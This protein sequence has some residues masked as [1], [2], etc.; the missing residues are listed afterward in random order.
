MLTRIM[1][2]CATVILYSSPASLA[3]E[4]GQGTWFNV[5]EKAYGHQNTCVGCLKD[6]SYG[7]DVLTANSGLA[8]TNA[9]K[10][11]FDLPSSGIYKMTVEYAA[12]EERPVSLIINGA[13]QD[14]QILKD[15]TGK[16]WTSNAA[17]KIDQGNFRFKAGDNIIEI[18]RASSFPH[19]RNF[20]FACAE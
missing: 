3:C 9:T 12:M 17:L 18:Q 20:Y 4:S 1:A 8:H 13:L 5:K 11:K 7:P 19:I 10:F 16:G 2:T 14:D 15:T 6:P